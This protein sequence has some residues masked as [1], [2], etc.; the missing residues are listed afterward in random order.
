MHFIMAH[1]VSILEDDYEFDN[2]TIKFEFDGC[3]IPSCVNVTIKD[4]MKVEP[5]SKIRR[6]TFR[7]AVIGSDLDNNINLSTVTG[8][9]YIED[10]DRMFCNY[11]AFY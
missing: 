7:V 11:V 3:D 6:D 5:W 4:D 8:K 9:V 10:N 1:S 2:S